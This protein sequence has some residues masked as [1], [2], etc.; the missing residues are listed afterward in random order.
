MITS[1]GVG[2]GSPVSIWSPPTAPRGANGNSF[3]QIDINNDGYMDF[4]DYPSGYFLLN[5]GDGRF[6]IDQF[7]GTVAL[8]DFDGD[9]DIL[10]EFNSNDNPLKNNAN[11]YNDTYLL[12][13]ENNGK[14]SFKRHEYF[15]EGKIDFVACT[16]YNADGN[17]ELIGWTITGKSK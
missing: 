15:I 17:Y 12:M 2:L 5:T 13:F 8:R 1:A 6:V 10:A 7:G 16:D 3:A 14:G 9:L 11:E 4:I